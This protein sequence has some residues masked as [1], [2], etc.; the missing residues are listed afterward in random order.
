MIDKV[1]V[2]TSSTEVL[3]AN[4]FRQRVML[5]NSTDEEISVSLGPAA[6]SGYGIILEPNGGSFVDE[7]DN[8]NWIF[9]GP[10]NAICA[11]GG[12]DLAVTELSTQRR[13]VNGFH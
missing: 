2:G 7:P 10:I 5:V 13:R 8:E 4:D 9:T 12:K 11:S 6:L 1:T 3:P